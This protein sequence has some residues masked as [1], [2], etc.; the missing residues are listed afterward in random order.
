M[1]VDDRRDRIGGI[2]ETI[3]EFEL[4]DRNRAKNK[5]HGY[6]DGDGLSPEY[7]GFPPLDRVWR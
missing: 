3:D 4:N 2:V 1:G 7:H 6:G 5:K